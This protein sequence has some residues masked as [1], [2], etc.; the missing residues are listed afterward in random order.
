MLVLLDRVYY[1]LRS[2]VEAMTGSDG[3]SIIDILHNIFEI[4]PFG[5]SLNACL[6]GR[7]TAICE[8]GQMRSCTRER[9]SGPL[10]AG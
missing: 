7:R 3:G 9:V 4:V 5:Q 8:M 6:G 1:S 2:R 10:S